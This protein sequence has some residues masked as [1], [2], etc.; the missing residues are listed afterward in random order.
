MSLGQRQEDAHEFFLKLLEH[1]DEE[2]TIFTEVC[3]L[4]DVFNIY[5]RSKTTCRECFRTYEEKDYLW[6]LSLPFPL[7]FAEHPSNLLNLY[8]LMDSYFDTEIV[9]D[10]NL[11]TVILLEIQ[12]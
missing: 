1:F 10:L 8:S 12:L 4:P 6:V 11:R 7:G 9:L 3:N 2:L 5:I